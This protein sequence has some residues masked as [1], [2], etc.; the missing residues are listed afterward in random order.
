MNLLDVVLLLAVIGFGFSGYHRGLLAGLVSLAGFVGGAALGVWLLPYL[1]D[2]MRPD[3][4]GSTLAALVV[5][6]LPAAA[7]Q[8]LAWPLAER[9]RSALVWAPARWV[10]GVGGSLLNA[11]AVLIVAWIAASSLSPTPSPGLNQAIQDSSVLGGVQDRMP[12]QAPT[13]FSRASDA[14]ND[15]GFPHVYNPFENMPTAEVPAPSGDNVTDAAVNAARQSTVKVHASSGFSGQAG[16]GFVY[17]DDLVLTNAHV[18]DDA[19]AVSVQVGGV[20][21]LYSAEIV[22]FNPDADVAL[23]QVPG[24]DAPTLPLTD[25]A[26]DAEPGDPAVVAGYPEDGGLDLQAA[27][28]AGRSAAQGQDIHGDNVVTRDIYTVRSTVRPGN[29]GGPL[30]TTDGQAAGMV[31]ARS[32]TDDETG[33]VLTAD[34]IRAAL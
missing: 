26:D 16:S 30:L 21:E 18:V 7:G 5:V 33:Y 8:A 1:I 15:A 4:M 10:D 27:T 12:Q 32:V 9:L 29:S 17:D 22:V 23:L 11:A 34:Q 24:L 20:G 3:T 19:G 14:L 2:P 28:V 31:F 6:L 13:W 25:D